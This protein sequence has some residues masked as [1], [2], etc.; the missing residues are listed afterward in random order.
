MHIVIFGLT[1]SSSWGNGHAT[2]WRGLCSALAQHGHKVTFLEKD[3]PYYAQHRDLND[4]QPYEIVLYQNWEDA[5]PLVQTILRE[6]D[7]AIITSYCPDA[8]AACNAILEASVAVKV[9]YD[10]DSPVTLERLQRGECVEYLPANGL[11]DFDLVLSYAGGSVLNELRS[12]LGAK[13]VAPLYG[14]VDPK[15]HYPADTRARYES[16]LSYLGTYSSTRQNVLEQLFIEPARRTPGKRFLI[17][18]ALY[19]DDFPWNENIYFVRHVPPSEHAAFYSS[20]RLTLNVTR[21]PMAE[22]G[23]CP[24][25]RLF[26]AAACETPVVSDVWE[27][28][29]DFF[30]PGEEILLANTPAEME[31]IL[32]LDAGELRSIGH[33]ARERV[34]ADHTAER[35]SQELTQLLEAAA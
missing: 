4:T 8:T 11:R 29:N 24:S 21:G 14:S 35:R 34:M 1:I 10:L 18:G 23:Y 32:K 17:G 12:L 26:E 5:G 30:V 15:V 31:E 27:G 25:G 9:F 19:P 28:I 3:V 2:L 20:S 6:C 13:R 22:A 16:D 33:A 7:S